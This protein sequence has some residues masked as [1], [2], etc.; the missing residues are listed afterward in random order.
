MTTL[1][2]HAKERTEERAG[3]RDSH[4]KDL[5][6]WLWA[7]GRSVEPEEFERYRIRK[8]RGRGYRI[9]SRHGVLYVVVRAGDRFVTLIKLDVQ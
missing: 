5:L 3:Q 8:L 6:V 1:T 2:G 7:R 9:A 4:A